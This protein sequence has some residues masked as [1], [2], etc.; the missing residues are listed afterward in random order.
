[1]KN[2]FLHKRLHVRFLALYATASPL[3]VLAWI[4][5]YYLL[6]EG[7]LRGRTGAHFLAGTRAASTF[8]GEW[9]RILFINITIGGLFIIV[10][11]LIRSAGGY[12]LGYYV[13]LGWAMLYAG[14]LGTNSFGLPIPGGRLPPSFA[15]LVRSGPYEIAAFILLAAATYPISKYQI[16]GRWPR[17]KLEPLV[18]HAGSCLS[19]EERLGLVVAILVLLAANAWEAYQITTYPS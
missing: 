13:P 11:N 8:L 7:V 4:L 17:Q 3:F 10:P 19:R 9:S 6:P 1:M 5:S 16:K 2:L 12:P 15:V 18:P 14:L